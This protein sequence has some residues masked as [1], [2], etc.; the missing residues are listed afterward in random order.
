MLGLC[1]WAGTILRVDLTIGKVSKVP[2][3]P[4]LAR[5]FIGGRGMNS[6]ILRQ[7]TAPG[8]D[9]LGPENLLIFGTGPLAGTS[10]PSSGRYTV[11]AKSPLTGILGDANSGGFWAP[12]LKYAGYDHIV[13]RGRADKPVYLWIDDEHVEIKDARGLAGKDTWET[14]DIIKEHLGD[15][16]IQVTCIGPAG[17]R[18]VRFASIIN[19]LSRAAG[20]TGVGAVMGSKKLKAIAVRGSKAVKIADPKAFERA[21][22]DSLKLVYNASNYE[23]YRNLGTTCLVTILN[24]QGAIGYKNCQAGTWE[25]AHE[26]SGETLLQKYVVRHKGCFGCRI[27]CSRYYE[28]PKGEYA[29]TAGEGPEYA[30]LQ[31]LG[32]SCANSDLASILYANNLANKLGLDAI[33]AGVT[34]AWAMECYEKGIISKRDT[35]GIELE[36]GDSHLIVAL[37]KMI[38]EREGFGNVLAEGPLRAAEKLGGQEY[39]VHV[40]GMPIHQ[41]QR[42]RKG[43]ALAHATSSRGGDHLRGIPIIEQFANIPPNAHQTLYGISEVGHAYSTVGKAQLVIWN[44]HLCAVADSL[45]ICKFATAWNMPLTGPRF[46]DFAKLLSAATGV[47]MNETEIVRAGERIVN[48][49]RLFNVREGIARKDDKLPK[50]FTEEAAPSGPGKG[51]RITPEDLETMLDEYYKTRGWRL[52]DGI[53]TEEKLR[54]LELTGCSPKAG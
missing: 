8:I 49:E 18:L 17:E 3:D 4:G 20:R 44:E 42:T 53:P 5:R 12:E 47:S 21:V 1:G 6:E 25:K 38:A 36:W 24:E 10:S 11:T 41:D 43:C 54:E 51:Q 46:G 32:A 15:D 13:I 39:V 16:D 22:E 9:P 37:L 48:T 2:I 23:T 45:E 27:Q 52:S 29:G 50:R 34:I 26:I 33:T 30:N 28:V 7:E 14:A 35:G 19:N 31:A 40:K